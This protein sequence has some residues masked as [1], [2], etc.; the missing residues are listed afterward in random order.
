METC[1]RIVFGV[2]G[3][4]RAGGMVVMY[5]QRRVWKVALLS[6]CARSA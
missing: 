2:R 5:V 4:L 1:E 6:V 3:L